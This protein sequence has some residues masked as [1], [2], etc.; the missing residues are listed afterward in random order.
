M[1][2]LL[3]LETVGDRFFTDQRQQITPDIKVTCNGLI[4]KWTVGADWD[5]RD[6]LYPELQVWR[7]TGSDTYHK[8]NSTVINI[9]SQSTTRIYEYDTSIPVL[10]GD[11]LGAF[12]PETGNSKL[13]LWSERDNGPIVYYV[14]TGSATESPVDAID[15][16]RMPSLSSTSYLPL[17]TVE[18]GMSKFLC[19]KCVVAQIIIPQCPQLQAALQVQ[20]RRW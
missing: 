6:S 19:S 11:I 13:R 14:D 2:I 12:L 1:C 8:I 17:I 16:Q 4:T 18:I 10:A 20:Y 3:G 5:I 7:G 9:T 15:L